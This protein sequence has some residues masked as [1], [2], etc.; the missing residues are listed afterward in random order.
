MLPYVSMRIGHLPGVGLTERESSMHVSMRVFLLLVLSLALNV[1][2]FSSDWLEDD[3]QRSL[4]PPSPSPTY[5]A[6]R[7]PDIGSRAADHSLPGTSTRLRRPP[8]DSSY[9]NGGTSEQSR[10]SIDLRDRTGRDQS[11]KQVAPLEATVSKWGAPGSLQGNFDNTATANIGT[12]G[13]FYQLGA[14][15]AVPPSTFRGWLE[16]SHPRFALLTSTM[17]PMAVLAVKGQWDN[18]DTT[19]RAFGIRHTTIKGRTLAETPLDNVRTIVVNCAGNVPHE[20][21]QQIRDFVARGGFLL[22]TDW[23]V[24]NLVERAFPGYIAWNGTKTD[25]KVVDATVVDPDPIL[26]S[27]AVRAAG[28]KLDDGSQVIRVLRRDV[29]VLVRSRMLARDD[30]DGQ[31]IL[32]VTFPFGRGQVLHLVGHFDNNA[33]LA[34]A[35]MLPDPAPQIGISLRQALAANFVV[36]GLR[37]Q[38]VGMGNR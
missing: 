16:K 36:E 29:R 5:R 30:P 17:D 12:G 7:P 2:A 37:Q 28:W 34:F 15:R 35:N 4:P 24:H 11:G 9:E 8:A 20:A 32:A 18:A 19:L 22:S 31:G 10:T 21:Y 33:T 6:P 27:G 3:S 14:A 1:P 13:F 25:N 23:T 38:S 26:F